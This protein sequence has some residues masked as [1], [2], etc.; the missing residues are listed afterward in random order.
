MKSRD[1][2][3]QVAIAPQGIEQGEETGDDGRE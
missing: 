3:A 1:G 2:P